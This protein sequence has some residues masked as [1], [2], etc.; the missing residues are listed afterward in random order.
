MEILALLAA[1][2]SNQEIA[3]DLSISARTAERHIGNI[4]PKIGARNR[5]EATAYAVRMGISPS[6]R[7]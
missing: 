4:Y 2:R 5:A 6:G 3:R 1:G 7:T